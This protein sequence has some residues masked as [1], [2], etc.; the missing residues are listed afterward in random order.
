MKGTISLNAC[1]ASVSTF[2]FAD[3]WCSAPGL[4]TAT[5]ARFACCALFVRVLG[6]GALFGVL[7]VDAI[8][9]LGDSGEQGF[10]GGEVWGYGKGLF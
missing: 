7:G 5:P 6:V 8:F 10:G 3:F 4:A 1:F 9:G 2:R